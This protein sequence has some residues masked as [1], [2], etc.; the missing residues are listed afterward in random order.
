[1]GGRLPSA[2]VTATRLTPGEDSL[3]PC[4]SLPNLSFQSGGQ[5]ASTDPGAQF[6]AQTAPPWPCPFKC[7]WRFL[8]PP[9]GWG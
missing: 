9:R 3:S 8:G 1:M 7:I 2:A 4:P 5:P 6:R